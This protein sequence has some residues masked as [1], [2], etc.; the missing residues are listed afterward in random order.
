VSQN[1][2]ES[3]AHDPLRAVAAS[4][5]RRNRGQRIAAAID[6]N[7]PLCSVALKAGGHRGITVDY[8]PLCGGTWLDRHW[9]ERLSSPQPTPPRLS[10]RLL[11]I[12]AIAAL[13]LAASLIVTIS[14]GAVKLW[15][16]VRNWAEAALRG[17][18]ESLAPQVREFAGRLGNP[19]IARLT[20]AGLDPAAIASLL[21][22]TGF[23]RLLSSVAAAPELA[24]LI[25]NGTYLK[26]LQE[27]AR[28]NVPNLADLKTDTIVSPEVR[29]AA[30]QIQSILRRTSVDTLGAVD[31]VVVDLLG[32]ETFQQLCRGG[33][34]ESTGN[35]PGS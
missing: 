26:A 5:P 13:V 15:P 19:Q 20:E 24:P 6:M 35:R 16:N 7:C 23:E 10:G 14:V 12:G 34:F 29:G 21:R 1:V 4:E 3:R 27:A 22:N 18:P 25:R 2:H 17:G 8:C 9:F 28:Q 31:P 32:T 33:F 11:R 30:E